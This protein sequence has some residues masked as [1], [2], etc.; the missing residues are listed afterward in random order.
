MC[1]SLIGEAVARTAVARAAG[2]ATAPAG[3]ATVGGAIMPL[4][5]TAQQGEW[6]D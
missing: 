6:A 5:G 4:V 1:C 2:V 3:M